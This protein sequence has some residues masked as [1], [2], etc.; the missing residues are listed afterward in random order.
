V[1][2]ETSRVH[3]NEYALSTHRK[4]FNEYLM[5]FFIEVSALSSK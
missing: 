2:H 1:S 5:V 3:Q 4:K